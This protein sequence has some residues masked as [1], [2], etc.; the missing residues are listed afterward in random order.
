VTFDFARIQGGSFTMGSPHR[1]VDEYNW[2]YEMP[3]RQVTIDRPYY[4]G[5]TEVTI[6]QFRLFVEQ[7]G[8]PTDAEKQGCAYVAGERRWHFEW[9]MD[10][11]HPGYLQ[12]DREPV[13][14]LGWYDAVAFCRWLTDKT[15]YHIRLPSEAEWEYA[16]RAGTAGDYAGPL[17]ELGWYAWNSAERTH[18]VAQK[19]PNAW[20]L[21]DM[22]GNAWEWV[23]DM[24]H[25]DGPGAPNDGSAWCDTP[26]VDPRGI[27]RGGSF[28][29]PAWLCRSY[30]RMQTPLGYTIHYNNGFRLACDVSGPRD[31]TGTARSV[32][33]GPLRDAHEGVGIRR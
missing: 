21:Y 6:E 20:G 12:T 17:G 27:T 23:Q 28:Y 13:V 15:G 22:H 2:T 5:V 25:G 11:R 32:L 30:I 9:L 29:N 14:C 10:W 24:Y 3:A 16:C 33:A 31:R 8:Y 18:P 4:L 1:Y 26:G 19:K 7:T